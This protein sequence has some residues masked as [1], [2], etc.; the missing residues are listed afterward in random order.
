MRRFNLAPYSPKKYCRTAAACVLE[1]R[2]YA[3]PSYRTAVRGGRDE[4]SKF[5]LY[6]VTCKDEKLGATVD[7]DM[8]CEKQA[9]A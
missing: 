5:R 4:K 8:C 1:L 9:K 2:R 6:V 3:L 7:L